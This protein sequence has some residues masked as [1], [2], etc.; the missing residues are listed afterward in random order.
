MNECIHKEILLCR[1][2]IKDTENGL[3]YELCP[4]CYN[5]IRYLK[6]F[7]VVQGG[8]DP[9]RAKHIAAYN[10]YPPKPKAFFPFTFSTKKG[11]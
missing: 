7:A 2:I 10:P 4:K 11:G 5:K 8:N 6:G 3:V 9:V 1:W